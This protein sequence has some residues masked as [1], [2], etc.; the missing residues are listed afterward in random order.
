MEKSIQWQIRS[1]I[2]YGKKYTVVNKKQHSLWKKV[3]SSKF[4]AINSL[5]KKVYSSKLEATFIMEKSI[6]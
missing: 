2:H 1:N 6:Q 4:D 5:W 3:F